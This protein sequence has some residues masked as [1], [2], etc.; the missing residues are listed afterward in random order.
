MSGILEC[1]VKMPVPDFANK[2]LFDPLGIKNLKWLF[3][4]S[5]QAMTG[6]GLRL[7]SRDLLKLAQLYLNNGKWN[8][9]QI[10]S[11]NWIEQ[12]ITPHVQ[13]D[14][15]TEYGYLW[16]LKSF[17][18]N[19]KKYKA[20]YMSG[21]GG[22]KILVFPELNMCVVITSNNYNTRGMHE[23]TDELLSDYIL[24]AIEE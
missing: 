4:P 15:E 5:G 13:I 16:W 1:A 23:Q 6:G 12:S 7:Q 18:S 14:D 24:R 21:N 22:N 20:Y 10:V 3:I 19:S 8:G 11:E 2:N 9:K 17:G